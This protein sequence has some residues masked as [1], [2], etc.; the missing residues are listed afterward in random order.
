MR[1]T[2]SNMF[3]Y[4]LLTDENV[5]ELFKQ[6]Q[7]RCGYICDKHYDALFVGLMK[8]A[9]ADEGR[10]LATHT[11]FSSKLR[12]IYAKSNLVDTLNEM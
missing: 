6:Q 1:L 7:N 10:N 2:F 9:L 4:L 5:S 12:S 8:E 3:G 11:L